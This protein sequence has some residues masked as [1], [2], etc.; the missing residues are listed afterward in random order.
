M[1]SGDAEA[2]DIR[3]AFDARLV[4][5]A[6]IGAFRASARRLV[7]DPTL[8][9][10][11]VAPI[12]ELLATAGLELRGAHIGPADEPWEP[13][14]VVW[15]R[16]RR[17]AVIQRWGFEPCCTAAFDRVLI[18]W[19]D[20]VFHES[21]PKASSTEALAHGHVALAFAEWVL[22]E[23]PQGPSHFVGFGQAL[24]EQSRGSAPG[25]LLLALDAERDGETLAAEQHLESAIPA[26][27]GFA[28]ALA[29]LASYASDRGDG[30]RARSLLRRAGAADATP[31]WRC[32]TASSPLPPGW[33]ATTPVLAALAA[34]SSSVASSTPGFLMLSG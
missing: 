2:V 11:P 30:S 14:G 33:A 13:P 19:D 10:A 4:P 6:G 17:Q 28:P 9:R 29:E 5:E 23:D 7:D 22:E 26:D 12:E 32:S 24:V 1:G 16:R 21:P 15:R 34:S 20:F 31:K 3:R 18:G 27:P 25:H 8:F